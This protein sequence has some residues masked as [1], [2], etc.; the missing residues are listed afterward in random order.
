MVRIQR[1]TGDHSDR[2]RNDTDA[3][4]RPLGHQL[5]KAA[6]KRWPEA[7]MTNSGIVLALALIAA[8]DTLGVKKRGRET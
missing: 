4:S 1:Q 5:R 8:R 2:G 6:E 3:H 7:V